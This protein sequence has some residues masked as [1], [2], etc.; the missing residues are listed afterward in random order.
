MKRNRSYS[1]RLLT[2]LLVVFILVGCGRSSS[3]DE[4]QN[5]KNL[6]VLTIGTADSGGTMVPAGKA[7][8]QIVSAKD[9]SLLIN[10]GAS[11][12]S[13]MNVSGLADG[14]IDLGLVSGDVAYAAYTGSGDFSEPVEGL[15]AIAALYTSTSVWV[16]PQSSD[17]EYVH[18]IAGKKVSA[19][20]HDSAT[21]TIA[22]V[23]VRALG[24]ADGGFT[25]ENRSYEAG[26]RQLQSGKLDAIHGFAGNPISSFCD[27]MEQLPCRILKFTDEELAEILAQ[28]QNYIATYIPAGTYSG[29]S[30]VI[31]T[32]G[33]KCLLCVSSAM[34]QEQAYQLTK[35]IYECREELA[36]A[37]PAMSAMADPEFMYGDLAVELHDGAAQFYK[38]Q[39]FELD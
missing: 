33:V 5:Q 16:V 10:I 20:P 9:D 18:D 38:E 13:A 22:R 24:L 28:N 26:T 39:G 15:R 35:I 2:A 8:A 23:T 27:M 14:E 21:D 6:T 12:G 29:Q 32:F 36:E 31:N 1:L 30:E 25:I 11:T 37:H 7:I 17:M 34:S 19:G 4:T 3:N